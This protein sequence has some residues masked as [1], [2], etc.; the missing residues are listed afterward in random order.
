MLRLLF[1]AGIDLIPRLAGL[2]AMACPKAF[3]AAL[4]C[5]GILRLGRE[6]PLIDTPGSLSPEGRMYLSQ[7]DSMIVARYEVPGIMKK[8]PS[9][10]RDD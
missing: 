6:I 5:V 2:R 1:G 9:S 4:A 8:T 3:G 7:R 10:Q